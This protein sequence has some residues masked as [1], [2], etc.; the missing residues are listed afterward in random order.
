MKKQTVEEINQA[1]AKN[2]LNL[3]QTIEV[4]ANVF[5]SQG[6]AYLDFNSNPNNKI[7]LLKI[8]LDDVKKNGETLPNSMVKQGLLILSWLESE[9]NV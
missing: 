4:L 7:D 9:E 6:S 8:V 2:D 3:Y 1:I 5:I